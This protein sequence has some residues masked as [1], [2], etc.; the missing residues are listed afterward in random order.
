LLDILDAAMRE[1]D[2][3]RLVRNLVK[4]ENGHMHV[5]GRAYAL[6]DIRRIYVL[7]AGKGVTPM[8]IALEDVLEGR[9]ERGLVIEKRMHGGMKEGERNTARLKKIEARRGGHPVPDESCVAGALKMLEIAGEA[10]EED[11]VFFCVQGGCTSLTTLPAEGLDIEELQEAT[12][13]LLASGCDILQINSVRTA[14]TRLSR[15]RLAREIYPASIINLVVNDYVPR[16]TGYASAEDHGW[17]PTAP[18]IG[19]GSNDLEKTI[20]TLKTIGRWGAIPEKIRCRLHHP[21]ASSS[22]LSLEDFRRIG[23]KYQTCI[24]AD[25]RTGVEAVQHAAERIG[26]RSMILSSVLEGEAKEAGRFFAGVSREVLEN[27]RPLPRPCL[28][29]AA[30]E[31][32]VRIEGPCGEGGRNQECVLSAAADIDGG[33]GIVIASVGTDGTDGP[34]PFAGGIIDGYTLSRA[35]SLGL[36]HR[37][38]LHTHDSSSFL[39]ALGDAILFKAP[40]T[41]IC[42]L[43]LILVT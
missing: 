38:Y 19:A 31:K 12:H 8:A 18:F 32:T 39:R 9:I 24:L 5:A 3:Y 29:I 14:L 21:E 41:N 10:G 35:R 30:G 2:S 11:I 36:D 26:L 28:L 33:Y 42:D 16:F 27:G 23:I 43:S 25:T 20:S 13:F 37:R 40:G 22:P 15:G 4:V 7:G 1:I 6:T 17:G 34:T